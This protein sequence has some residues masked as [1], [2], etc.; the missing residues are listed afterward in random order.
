MKYYHVTRDWFLHI[1]SQLYSF[2]T[3]FDLKPNIFL[4]V[5]D[6]SHCMIFEVN[7]KGDLLRTLHDPTGNITWGLSEG[8]ELSDGRV[9]LGSFFAPFM[10]LAELKENR[11]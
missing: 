7:D 10:G 6:R 5:L 9:A 1:C 11:V 8:F 4:R 2:C 3:I